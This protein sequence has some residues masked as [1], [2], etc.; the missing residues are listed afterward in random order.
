MT[1]R[2]HTNWMS[3][4]TKGFLIVSCAALMTGCLNKSQPGALKV[5]TEPAA[6]VI[7]DG[8]EVG[9]SPFTDEKLESGEITLKLEPTDTSLQPWEGLV[10]ITPGV[11]TVVVQDLASTRE[12]SAGEVL[13]MEP[14]NQSM[15]GL[16]VVSDPDA[17]IVK[18][19][20]E[21]KGFTPLEIN[22]VETGNHQLIISSPGYAD[23]TI[24]IQTQTGYTLAVSTKLS[25]QEVA[26][27]P[28]T[29]DS[30]ATASASL[31]GTPSPKVSGTPTPKV[32]TSPTPKVSGSPTPK[33]SGSPTPTVAKVSGT[34]SP[35]P[36]TTSTATPAKPYVKI[37]STPTGWLRVRKEAN[38]SSEEVAKVNPGDMFPLKEEQSGWFEIEY[39]KGKTGWISGQYAQKFE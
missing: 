2:S 38:V 23:R 28:I 31:S 26:T 15:A 33:V 1:L 39:E 37:S 8:K 24:D 11:Y 3:K 9:N 12:K 19:N 36:S 5:Q 25:K 29:D 34:P 7:I 20:G 6:K 17:A 21:S 30:T 27:T 32:S 16:T 35:K 10:D 14:N 4:I 13:T 22:Q 18:L